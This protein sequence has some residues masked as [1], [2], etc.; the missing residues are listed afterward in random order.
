M[1]VATIWFQKVGL[2]RINLI[3]D[4][5]VT[6]IE[7]SAPGKGVAKALCQKADEVLQEIATSSKREFSHKISFLT[8]DA[9]QKLERYLVGEGVVLGY[10][11]E[12]DIWYKLYQPK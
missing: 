3:K 6:Y 2:A 1:I 5:Y 12:G 4:S 9:R 8:E 7:S 11:K 10:K